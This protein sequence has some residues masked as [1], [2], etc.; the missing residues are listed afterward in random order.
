MRPAMILR[1]G[2]YTPKIR[3][4]GTK[5]REPKGK[6]STNRSRWASAGFKAYT[7]EPHAPHAHPC[8]PQEVAKDFQSFLA[9]LQS[10]STSASNPSSNPKGQTSSDSAKGHVDRSTESSSGTQASGEKEEGWKSP[11]S[12]KAADYE[13]I[14]EAP[15][16]VWKAREWTEREIDAIMVSFRLKTDTIAIVGGS[17][18]GEVS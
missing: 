10:T 5:W 3:F 7:T 2:Q 12:G 1:A 13:V 18:P 14:W 11:S 17:S 4:L 8:A 16:S 6:T 9:K 15:E